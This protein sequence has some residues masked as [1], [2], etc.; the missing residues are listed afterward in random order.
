V[1]DLWPGVAHAVI[2]L[3]DP[4]KGEQLVLLTEEKGA[5]REALSAYAKDHGIGELSVPRTIKHV[6]KM[7]LLGTGKIDYPAATALVEG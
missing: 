2:S 7:P 5:S 1:S 3:P 6:E 4:K